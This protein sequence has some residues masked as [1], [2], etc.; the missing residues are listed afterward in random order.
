[1]SEERVRGVDLA[2]TFALIGVVLVNWVAYFARDDLR[3]H[4]WLATLFRGETSPLSTRFAATF[5]TVAGIGISLLTRRSRL[6][7]DPVAIDRDRWRL[8]RRGVLLLVAA[9]PLH[10]FWSGEILHFYACYFI[11]ASFVITASARWLYVLSAAAVVGAVAH[12]TA[13]HE[14]VGKRHNQALAWLGTADIHKPKGLIAD[15]LASGTH[16]LLPW[17]AFVFVGMAIGRL[18]LRDPALDR[19]LLVAGAAAAAA[20]HVTRDVVVALLPNSYDWLAS[21]NPFVPM[22]LYVLSAGGIAVAA[23]GMCLVLGRRLAGSSVILRLSLVGQQTFSLYY[24]HATVAVVVGRYVAGT[25]TMSVGSA[26]LSAIAFWIAAVIVASWYRRRF[27]LGPAERLLR[28]F[29]D[30]PATSG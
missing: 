10:W 13:L 11:V 25:R 2:R 4:D 9:Y 21:T 16:P 28:R 17:L 3:G 15:L 6:S 8:R 14:L 24:L 30:D 22:P 23:V 7:A 19:R 26:V 12:E 27:G 20:A 1:M 18:D 5:V 29:S